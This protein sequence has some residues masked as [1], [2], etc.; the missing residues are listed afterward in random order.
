M[1]AGILRR[2]RCENIT[3]FVFGAHPHPLLQG[4]GD[5]GRLRDT[6]LGL[7][8]HQQIQDADIMRI[9]DVVGP[10]LTDYGLSGETMAK[11]RQRG[12]ANRASI[13]YLTG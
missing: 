5:R 6:I 8:V 2:L 4:H 1:R 9:A 13:N 7:P 12:M 10:L 3:P 11:A